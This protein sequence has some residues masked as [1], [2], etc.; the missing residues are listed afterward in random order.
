MSETQAAGAAPDRDVELMLAFGSASARSAA[1]REVSGAPARSVETIYYD[2]PRRRLHAAGYSLRL[3][4][5]GEQWSQSIK[6]ADGFS[7]FEQDHPLRGAIPDFSLIEGTPIA[8]LVDGGDGL[9]PM[10]VTRVQRRSRRRVADGSRIEYS[11][12]EGEVIAH[13]RSWPILELELEL[14]AGAPGALFDQGRRLAQDEAFVPAFMSKADRGYALVDGILGE[15]VGIRRSP[16]RWRHAGGGGL[17]S[18]GPPLPA[19]A[20]PERRSDRHRLAPRGRAPGAHR[21][22]TPAGCDGS[23]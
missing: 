7:R 19:S 22:S 4:R 9:A 14:K 10:F 1:D 12:D 2:T 3:R 8:G 16:P 20:F 13:D 17:P 6:S 5:D 11:L 23:L 18:P 15:P 21:A